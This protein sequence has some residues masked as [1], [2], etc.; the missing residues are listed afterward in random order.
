MKYR[1]RC[2]HRVVVSSLVSSRLLP[3]VGDVL[4]AFVADVAN[5][6]LPH[7]AAIT[8]ARAL[9]GFSMAVVVGAVLAATMSSSGLFSRNSKFLNPRP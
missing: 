2:A 9:A 4:S 3:S 8:V 6:E 7:Q 1:A 5:G